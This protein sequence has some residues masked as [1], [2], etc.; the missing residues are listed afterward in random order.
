MAYTASSLPTQT[1]LHVL[2]QV[3]SSSEVRELALFAQG[4]KNNPEIQNRFNIRPSLNKLVRYYGIFSTYVIDNFFPAT[5]SI[6]E[7]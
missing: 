1:Y 2:F 3:E 6:L 7:F 5:Y 4:L